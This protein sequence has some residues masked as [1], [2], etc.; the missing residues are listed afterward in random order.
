MVKSSDGSIAARY[1]YDPFGKTIFSE[2]PMAGENSYRFSTKYLDDETGLYY[3]G[4]RY[5]D[6]EMGRWINRDPMEENG[7]INLYAFNY[8]D[9]LGITDYLGL[10]GRLCGACCAENIIPKITADRTKL[11]LI[12]YF[13]HDFE[14]DISLSY[15]E[16]IVA[17][18]C[19]F[20]WKEKSNKELNSGLVPGIDKF[21]DVTESVKLYSPL[22]VADWFKRQQPTPGNETIK[23]LDQPYLQVTSPSPYNYGRFK[24]GSHMRWRHAVK[25]V[26]KSTPGC[27]KCK[28]SS[29]EATIWHDF[30]WNGGRSS[31]DLITKTGVEG[32]L[33]NTD[34]LPLSN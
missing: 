18:D 9:S 20:E 22:S 30:A 5:Y 8:N 24:D 25:I 11:Y 3:Y 7:G 34:K 23:F 31:G 26:V 6:A 19:E 33:F 12:P 17:G 1:E 28:Y 27:T 10:K 2:G 32:P 4:Y 13:G 15:V 16:D 14:W 21:V 29:V